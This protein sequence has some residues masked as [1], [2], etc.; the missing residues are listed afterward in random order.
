[1]PPSSYFGTFA[2]CGGGQAMMTSFFV[3]R[4]GLSRDDGGRGVKM[5][6]FR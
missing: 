3:Q 1:M 4:G 2:V 5:E 6:I